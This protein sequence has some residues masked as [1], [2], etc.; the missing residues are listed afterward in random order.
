MV[1]QER[2]V[3]TRQ[4]L[5]RAAAEVFAQVGFTPASL[6]TICRRAGVSAGA[7]HFHFANKS[8]LAEAV[9]DAASEAVNRIIDEAAARQDTPL[10]AVVDATHGLM[11]SLAGDAVVRGGFGLAGDVSRR[12]RS[13]LR[14]QWQRWIEDSL[15][16]AE[17]SGGLAEGVSSMAA[18]HAVVAATVGFEVLGVGDASWLSPQNLTRFWLLMLPRLAARPD[19]EHLACAGSQ[20]ETVSG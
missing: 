7:L 6:S 20:S 19:V 3:R 11:R 9:E 4:A 13:P 18:A 16:R 8:V 15:R 17:S 1:K 14:A 12:E 5:I 10:Q 2:A